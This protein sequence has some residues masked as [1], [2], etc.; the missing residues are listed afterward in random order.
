MDTEQTTQNGSDPIMDM[1]METRRSDPD[2]ERFIHIYLVDLDRMIS[3][4]ESERCRL[5][6][7]LQQYNTMVNTPLFVFPIKA[8]D[9]MEMPVLGSTRVHEFT[10][11]KC[12]DKDWVYM[13]DWELEEIEKYGEELD[14][15]QDFIDYQFAK[16]IFKPLTYND[17][18]L[19]LHTDTPLRVDSPV[20]VSAD[21]EP[22]GPVCEQAAADIL[23]VEQ[24]TQGQ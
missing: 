10:P 16:V 19:Q 1:F 20:E 17:M 7:K 14:E 9:V 6:S 12:L 3:D 15:L 22:I 2:K 8:T 21:E 18:L 24:E 11:A 13:S 23:G 5:A 4:N